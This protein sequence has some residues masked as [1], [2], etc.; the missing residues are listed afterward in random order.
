MAPP[1]NQVSYNSLP[2]PLQFP[3][4]IDT[5]AN[6]LLVVASHLSEDVC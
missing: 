1:H 6:R 2:P 3:V 5:Q 4:F